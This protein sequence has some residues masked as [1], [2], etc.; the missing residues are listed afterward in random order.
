MYKFCILTLKGQNDPYHDPDQNWDRF[1]KECLLSYRCSELETLMTGGQKPKF[2]ICKKIFYL[3]INF[4]QVLNGEKIHPVSLLPMIVA[5]ELC[6]L[7][8]DINHQLKIS[9]KS[10]KYNQRK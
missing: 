4:Y 7:R 1:T 5:S 2:Y 9:L 3:F 6:H 8:W 10:N